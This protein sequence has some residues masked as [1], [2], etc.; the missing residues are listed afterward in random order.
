[1][2]FVVGL[3]LMWAGAGLLWVASHATGAATPWQVYQKIM[4]GIEGVS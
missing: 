1:M 4:Q 3:I 2:N